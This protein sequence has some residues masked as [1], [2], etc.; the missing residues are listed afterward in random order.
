[1]M[2]QPLSLRSLTCL[3]RRVPCHP[4]T[5]DVQVSSGEGS[6]SDLAAV[7]SVGHGQ[8]PAPAPAMAP[9]SEGGRRLQQVGGVGQ[10]GGSG[11]HGWVAHPTFLPPVPALFH[12]SVV[13]L[14]RRCLLSWCVQAESTATELPAVLAPVAELPGSVGRRL[15]QVGH[16]CSARAEWGVLSA[17][18]PGCQL[19]N[20]W[21]SPRNCT[22]VA[23]TRVARTSCRPTSRLVLARACRPLKQPLPPSPKEAPLPATPDGLSRTSSRCAHQPA[24]LLPSTHPPT[25]RLQVSSGEGST[26]DLAAVGSVGHGQ[27][28]APTGAPSAEGNEEGTATSTP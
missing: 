24:A 13:S 18:F 11:V 26:S 28:P 4:G 5:H 15:Q 8:L 12:A 22:S 7:G 3:P 10:V 6:T 9:S 21:L 2:W 20:R 23:S 17:H 27:L 14:T 19:T 16:A 1:M 25:R